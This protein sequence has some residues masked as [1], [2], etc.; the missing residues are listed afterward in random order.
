MKE[1]QMWKRGEVEGGSK[2]EYLYRLLTIR[3]CLLYQSLTHKCTFIQPLT[4][5]LLW[6]IDLLWV[7]LLRLFSALFK[8]VGQLTVSQKG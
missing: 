6:L 3:C 7:K 2:Y 8:S 4:P 1:A 5:L